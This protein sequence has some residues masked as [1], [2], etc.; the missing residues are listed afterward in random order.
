MRCT[1]YQCIMTHQLRGADENN[2]RGK[3]HSEF[4]GIHI[5]YT[6]EISRCKKKSVIVNKFI[7]E[8][9]C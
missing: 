9:Q 3:K 1:K 5:S 7:R 8:I 6:K 2:R 4:Y